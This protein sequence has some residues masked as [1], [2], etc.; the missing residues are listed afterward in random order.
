MEHTIKG[1]PLAQ[2]TYEE[3]LE[4]RNAGERLYEM[5]FDISEADLD[6]LKAL[7]LELDARVEQTR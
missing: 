7:E 3:I 4:E 1:K 2:C 6:R 5:G